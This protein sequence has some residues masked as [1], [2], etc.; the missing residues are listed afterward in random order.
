MT[1]NAKFETAGNSIFQKGLS[2]AT[3]SFEMILNSPITIE[4][5][6]YN[7]EGVDI[8]RAK[9][10]EICHVLKTELLGDLTGASLLIFSESEIE[11][12]VKVC[13]ASNMPADEEG[14]AIMKNGF[15]AEIDNILSSSVITEVANELD[16][17]LYGG[18]PKPDMIE[19]GELNNYIDKES[20]SFKN[21]FQ[22]KAVF[23]GTEL[24][25]S[26]DFIWMF[27]SQVMEK[28]SVA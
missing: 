10:N 18:V 7:E 9:E 28:L 27:N 2:A 1:D 5:I 21:T 12:I 24:E 8:S 11:R 6:K 3:K 25:I 13:L 26:P 23:H 4:N 20:K 19:A 17:F 22:F 14:Q 15:I 16:V